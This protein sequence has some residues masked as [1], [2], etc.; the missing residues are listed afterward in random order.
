MIKNIM[1]VDM[2]DIYHSQ[3][4]YNFSHKSS[5]VE[6]RNRVERSTEITLDLFDRSKSKGTFFIVGEMAERYKDIVEEVAKRGHHIGTHSHL[7]KLVHTLTRK[8]FMFDLK[9]SID[10]LQDITNQN[11]D[12]FRAPAWSFKSGKTD[13][14]WDVLNIC[15]IRYDSSIFPTKNFLYGQPEAPRFI[16]SVQHN[17]IEIPP[18]T[19]QVL[20]Y[21]IPF[22]GGFYLRFLPQII[23]D[24]SVK[25][26]N[27]SNQPVISYFHPWELDPT[28]DK[29]TELMDK[30]YYLRYFIMH[31][32]IKS[33]EK[34]LD[35]LMKKNIF[36]SI[37]DY[38]KGTCVYNGQ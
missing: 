29:V 14:F 17:I 13:W 31:Y 23:I 38:Y 28:A 10:I 16:N 1:T 8:E 11:I 35:I 33:T 24:W 19:V 18:S 2:E 27:N 3:S 4:S 26:I 37:S 22:S 36:C 7:H 12:A 21:N 15:G 34:K 20:D 6:E 32:N 30:G 25:H 5:L 9:K